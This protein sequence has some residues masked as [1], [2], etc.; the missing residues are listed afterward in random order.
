MQVRDLL[1]ELVLQML[2]KGMSDD[3]LRRA[4]LVEKDLDLGK[5]REMCRQYESAVA[6]VDVIKGRLKISEVDQVEGDYGSAVDRIDGHKVPTSHSRP[7]RR[8]GR[9]YVCGAQ[10]HWAREC[11]RRQPQTGQSRDRTGESGGPGRVGD[12]RCYSCNKLG[13]IS[14]NCPKAGPAPQKRRCRIHAVGERSVSSDSE[15]SL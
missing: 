5:A 10:G 9:C 12:G 2:I 7:A 4:L 15:E 1:G 3:K 8:A 13:H 14:W 6:V 11:R